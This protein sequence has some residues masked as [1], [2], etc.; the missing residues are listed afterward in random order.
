MHDCHIA[1]KRLSD[2]ETGRVA[3]ESNDVFEHFGQE[4]IILVS[5]QMFA[6][7]HLK[8]HGKHTSYV[9]NGRIRRSAARETGGEGVLAVSRETMF[10]IVLSCG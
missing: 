6:G 3:V 1:E 5:I 2:V 10:D 9:L 7:L 4:K 8:A